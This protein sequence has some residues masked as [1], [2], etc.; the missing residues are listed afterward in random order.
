VARHMRGAVRPAFQYLVG[1]E[2]RWRRVAGE[3]TM[4]LDPG[5]FMD[6]RFFVGR[7]DRTLLSTIN[8]CV[9]SGS[10]CVD[11]GAHKGYVTL[12][13]ARACG[14][15][16]K[17]YAFEPDPRA[18]RAL[19]LNVI[20][21]N[22]EGV[23]SALQRGL[24]DA[25][26]VQTL[27]LSRQLGWSS[28]FMNEVAS[29]TIID[30]VPVTFVPFDEIY[31]ADA[32]HARDLAFV[33]IDCEGSECQVIDGMRGTLGAT[34]PV[35]WIEVNPGALAAAGQEPKILTGMIRDLG[36]EVFRVHRPPTWLGRRYIELETL[37]SGGP[38]TD[39][40]YDVLCVRR[41]GARFPHL[42]QSGRVRV[43]GGD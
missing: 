5:D 26:S 31:A 43:A 40:Y 10:A 2:P 42:L 3:Y 19:S 8:L 18:F 33:K 15:S 37:S 12:Q 14:Q 38:V 21:N 34:D 32:G 35:L 28:R 13:M 39:S 7:Y 25:A 9:T 41:A 1:A 24:G 22:L 11:A 36:F 6:R 16:G 29:P 4:L 23:V 20:R 27:Y 30:A 17:V